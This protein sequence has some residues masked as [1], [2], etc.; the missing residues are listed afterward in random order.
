MVRKIYT[1][2]KKL[3]IAIVMVFITIILTNLRKLANILLLLGKIC[4]L[5]SKKGKVLV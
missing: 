2:L 3:K 1:I 5:S 4:W